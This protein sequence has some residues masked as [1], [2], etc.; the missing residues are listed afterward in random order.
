M[1]LATNLV[2]TA[3][4]AFPAVMATVHTE[5]F[6][7][8]LKKD[9]CVWSAADDRNRCNATNGKPP[10]KGVGQFEYNPKKAKRSS[11]TL[12]RRYTSENTNTSF[13]ISDG[14]G[15][16]GMYNSTTQ[17]GACLWVG[18]EQ[19]YGNDSSTAGWLNGAKTSNCGKQ[20]YV[21][22]KGRP[23]KPFYVPVVDG[24]RFYTTN[25]TVGC[26]QIGLTKKTFHDLEPTAEEIE[27]GYLGDLIW[28][29]NN[30]HG[31]KSSNSPV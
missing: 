16:C 13:Q 8:F 15:I 23:D 28:D 11:I 26:F 3:L 31:V 25:V 27:R 7:Y 29:F 10:F 22:R 19:L 6:N 24:C 18:S 20:L 1:H 2:I 21:Q 9:G 12:D 5:C 30:E 14:P 4:T 17:P